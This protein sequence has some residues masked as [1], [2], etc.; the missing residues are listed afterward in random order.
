MQPHRGVLRN[1]EKIIIAR[2]VGTLT[3][4]VNNF[5]LGPRMVSNIAFPNK[6]IGENGF[7][8]LTKEALQLQNINNY[9][10]VSGRSGNEK[11]YNSLGLEYPVG[12]LTRSLAGRYKEYD[13]DKD[14]L[15]F[16]NKNKFLESYNL[17]IDLF[18]V[19]ENE[20]KL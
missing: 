13:T 2:Y 9:S 7:S 10:V 12:S 20:K 6:S 14:N 1:D 19:L 5:F 3:R 18:Y 15:E 4:N 16:I 17:L 8:S 11:A